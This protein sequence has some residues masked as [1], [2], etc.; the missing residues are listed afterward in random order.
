MKPLGN[1]H[2]LE[3]GLV[4]PL[5]CLQYAMNLPTSVMITGCNSMAMLEQA[6]EAA[7]IFRPLDPDQ[8]KALLAKTARAARKGAFEPYKTTHQ[9]DSTYTH[10]Q[11]LG[12]CP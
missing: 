2:V 11:W 12:F 7:R 8:V 4:T 10:P 6:L 9:Y 5:E 1:G 3:S